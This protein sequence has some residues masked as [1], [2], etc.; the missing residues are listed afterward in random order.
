M[1]KK[2]KKNLGGG[3]GG[4][5]PPEEASVFRRSIRMQ[6]HIFFGNVIRGTN[7]KRLQIILG[8]ENGVLNAL[9]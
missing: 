8:E 4:G 1:L 5:Q 6:I 7:G 2:K 9:D 3:G